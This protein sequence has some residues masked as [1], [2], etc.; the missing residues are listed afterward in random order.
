MLESA[1]KAWVWTW[2]SEDTLHNLTALRV[3]N[4]KAG[5]RLTDGGGLRLDV[6]RSGRA[7]WVFRYKSPVTGRERYMGLGPLADIGLARARELAASAREIVRKH[8]DPIEE[9]RE[10][11]ASARAQATRGVTFEAYAERYVT[12]HEATWKNA[13]HR[14]QWRST[15]RVY[16]YPTIGHLPVADVNT[17]AVLSLLRPIWNDKPE[18]ASR[19]RGR[20][21]AV[22]SAAKAE[23]LR[24]GENPALWRGHLDHLLPSKRKV[25]QVLHHP[26]LPYG[27]MPAFFAA[28]SA[29]STDAARLLRFIILTAC[30]YGEAVGMEPSEVAG[31]VWRV[32]ANRMKAGKPHEVPLS[33]AATAC[34]PLP[35]VSDVGL[36][37][38]IRRHTD[39]PATTH[40][41]RSC[42]RD[43][44]GDCTEFPRDV[45]EAALAHTL[46][47]IEAAYR[48]GTAL[49]KRRKLMD[50]WAQY[51]TQAGEKGRA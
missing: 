35:H 27:Q 43:W 12:T 13:V 2:N 38:C 47:K 46:G 32:P 33:A 16:V 49:T 24:T 40:G 5:D 30:R 18:T 9:R 22:L 14:R 15:L 42:F 3:K 19:V 41:M 34:L 10:A 48:R 7:S 44:A 36:A 6:D 28:L 11:K 29:D 23:G 50:V 45:I 25:R 39:N 8:G 51:C 26:A 37:N 1:P 21:E 4:A 31:N 20:I 17:E